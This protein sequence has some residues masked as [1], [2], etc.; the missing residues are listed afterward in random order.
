MKKF[1]TT[2]MLMI[3]FTS[4]SYANCFRSFEIKSENI[5]S[6]YTSDNIKF[7]QEIDVFKKNLERLNSSYEVTDA[8]LTELFKS[9][10]LRD[11]LIK[12]IGPVYSEFDITQNFNWMITKSIIVKSSNYSNL[13]CNIFYFYKD[14]K[15]KK[16][17]LFGFYK[18][19]NN[20]RNKNVK[21]TY[22]EV[23][24]Q[25]TKKFKRRPKKISGRSWDVMYNNNYSFISSIWRLRKTIDLFI[26]NYD[27]YSVYNVQYYKFSKL[28]I[29]KYRKADALY[30]AERKRKERKE[31]K[32]NIAN[33]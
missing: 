11:V 4:A 33:F 23:N 25:L 31:V 17:K 32:N 19:L 21:T 1:L 20:L 26:I 30:H 2:I 3:M 27:R 18:P 9:I 8:S 7:E 6:E 14:S 24:K 29:K 13:I 10:D 5:S 16:Y 15:T 22:N 28:G 12:E